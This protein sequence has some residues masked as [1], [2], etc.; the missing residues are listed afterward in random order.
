MVAGHRH[1]RGYGRRGR[2]V[3]RSRIGLVLRSATLKVQPMSIGYSPENGGTEVVPGSHSGT[4]AARVVHRRDHRGVPDAASARRSARAARRDAGRSLRRLRGHARAPRRREPLDRAT[5]RVL[6][7]VLPAMGG[8]RRASRSPFRWTSPA[9]CRKR[10][11]H[12][13]GSRFTRR[14]W[15]S[16]PPH[17][18]K[19]TGPGAMVDDVRVHHYIA[20]HGSSVDAEVKA[21]SSAR[22]VGHRTVPWRWNFAVTLR[23]SLFRTRS[24]RGDTLYD[25]LVSDCLVSA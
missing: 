15:V 5:P 6:E 16:S 19:K 7:S 21:N 23:H 17:L 22:S 3:G 1:G 12:S 4:R 2:V 24:L 8:S 20:R 25:C 13:S 18:L 11:S 9:R 10:S 14:S